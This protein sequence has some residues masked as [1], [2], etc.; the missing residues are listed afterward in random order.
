[1]IVPGFVPLHATH[2]IRQHPVAQRRLRRALDVA[3]AHGI[4]PIL[5]SGGAVHPE[6]TP[7]VE[8]DGMAD[9]LL[10]R[11]WPPEQVLRERRARHTHTNLR[12]CGRI[13]LERGWDAALVVS[14]AWQ[15]F[16]IASP[17]RSGLRRRCERELGYWPGAV[18]RVDLR[19]TRFE[20]SIDVLR[21]GPDPLDP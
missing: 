6:G 21:P 17:E 10:E 3:R 11:G 15:S 4:G 1:M 14:D 12:N 19:T 9:W 5:V 2:P 8:A 13:L 7:W 20:P 18:R 16:Y